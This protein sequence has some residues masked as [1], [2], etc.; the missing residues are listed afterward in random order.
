MSHWWPL[1]ASLFLPPCGPSTSSVELAPSMRS[2]ELKI[3]PPLVALLIAAAM[4]GFSGTGRIEMPIAVRVGAG[5]VAVLIGLGIAVSG[6]IAFRRAHTTVS[7]LKPETASRL[8]TSGVYRFT[9]NPM[10]LGLCL[11]LT[12]WAFVLSSA[13]MLLGPVAF[14]LYIT[15]FQIVP[16]ERMLSRLFPEAF[17]DYQ[18]KVRRWI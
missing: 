7:P 5:L 10:Y 4:W 14:I 1:E 17:A 3:P 13:L 8:V 18:A 9:R 11:V 15:Q 12:G 16:E 6:V 2:L